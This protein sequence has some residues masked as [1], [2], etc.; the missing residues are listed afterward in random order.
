MAVEA[1]KC[2]G[3]CRTHSTLYIYTQLCYG[4]QCDNAPGGD[5]QSVLLEYGKCASV[6]DDQGFEW[7]WS[8]DESVQK[9]ILHVERI[10]LPMSLPREAHVPELRC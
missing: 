3:F 1:T 5:T 10:Y 8:K 9:V 2:G 6:Q 7:W 4:L